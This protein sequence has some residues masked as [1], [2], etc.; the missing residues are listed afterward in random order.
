MSEKFIKLL[1][2]LLEEGFSLE[3]EKI[4][5]EVMVNLETCTKIYCHV[6]DTE[7]GLLAKMR[8]NQTHKIK[9]WDDVLFAVSNC[10]GSRG[11]LSSDWNKILKESTYEY[12]E[13]F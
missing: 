2:K 1:N 5:G 12:Y 13:P 6:Y 3:I 10:R 4:D 11:D 8:Y 7:D 9:D